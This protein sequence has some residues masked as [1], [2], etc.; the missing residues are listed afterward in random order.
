[1]QI[2]EEPLSSREELEQALSARLTAHEYP[3]AIAIARQLVADLPQEKVFICIL[4]MLLRETGAAAQALELLTQTMDEAGADPDLLYEISET[5][6]ALNDPRKRRQALQQALKLQPNHAS[7]LLGQAH[8]LFSENKLHAAE[9]KVVAALESE[10]QLSEAHGLMGEIFNARKEP[11][12]AL[13]AFEEALR[14]D[15][16]NPQYLAGRAQLLLRLRRFAEAR[17]SAHQCLLHHPAQE[18]AALVLAESLI[19]LNELTEAEAYC[20]ALA[21]LYPERLEAHYFLGSCLLKKGD[22][23][24]ACRALGRAYQLDP[25]HLK[26]LLAFAQGLN[27]LKLHVEVVEIVEKA[28]VQLPNQP[29]LLEFL[30]RAHVSLGNGESAK[31]YY[32]KAIKLDPNNQGLRYQLARSLLCNQEYHT[33][34]QE[35]ASCLAALPELQ[36]QILFELGYAHFMCGEGDKVLDLLPELVR[37]DGSTAAQQKL[38]F[39]ITQL[40]GH[41]IDY[42][43]Q[44][45]RYNS[46]VM[47]GV[48]PGTPEC[49][50][51]ECLNVGFVS[52]DFR[53]HPV[54][55]FL[56]DVIPLLAQH[57]IRT[58]AYS[59]CPYEDSM[60]AKLKAS[61]SE[62]RHIRYQRVEQVVETVRNDNIDILIDLSGHTEGGCLDAFARR[63]APVQVSWLG[64]WASTGLETMDYLLADPVALPVEEQQN[65][66][67]SIWY[68]PETRL[69]FSPPEA[70]GE[71]VPT[72]ALARGYVTF[73]SY[74]NLRKVSSSVLNA[75]ASVLQRVPASRFR[76]QC[77]QFADPQNMRN[78]LATFG[79]LGIDPVRIQLVGAASYAQYLESYAEVDILLDSFP[80]PGGTTTCEAIWM[81]VPTL[82]LMGKSMVARQ[83]GSLLKAAGLDDW[84][85]HD[86][87]EY[88][89]KAQRFAADIAALNTLRL[90]MREKTRERALFNADRFAEQLATALHGMH[91]RALRAD[92]A[93]S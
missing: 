20:R 39:M 91:E 59:N 85:A 47:R 64:Y 41:Q 24:G 68:L 78:I 81:G 43:E 21:Q 89:E 90:S 38:L 35:L 66:T 3:Q 93:V 83:G 69:C 48:T 88:R 14:Y 74:Q 79:Q 50:P 42:L 71:V 32:Q 11:A 80:F 27:N 61:F 57:G 77:P 28:L 75:W 58:F 5:H 4:A 63:P 73:G 36:P 25:G 54:G 92:A 87:D 37:Q 23:V 2:S 18:S 70:A 44:A 65:F 31:G 19:A 17:D 72:P 40:D 67:E 33:A 76:W 34:R 26:T 13:R 51:V 60:T 53:L 30:G 46:K 12:N 22:A 9:K 6:R 16:L 29:K 15:P 52:A 49:R 62:W 84:L 8:L 7:S 10:A 45:R 56:R 55:H 1:M 86:I 82:T